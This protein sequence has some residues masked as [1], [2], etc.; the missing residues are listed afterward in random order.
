MNVLVTGS[1]GF[2]GKNLI[3]RLKEEKD[4]GIY[5]YDT[6][7]DKQTLEKYCKA[8]DFV[9]HLAGINRPEDEREFMTGNYG[10][11]L[12]LLDILSKY[13]NQCPVMLSS[14]IQAVYDNNYGRSKKAAEDLLLDYCAKNGAD[15]F[16]CR[17]PNVFGKWCKPNYNSAVAT[18]CHNIARNILITIDEPGKEIKLVYID[19]VAEGLIRLLHSGTSGTSGAS[20]AGKGGTGTRG[21]SGASNAGESGTAKSG[22][23]ENAYYEIHPVYSV[24]LESLTGLLYSF[25]EYR[26]KGYI[27]DLADDFTRKLYGTYL[28]Y[29]P[30]D[31]LSHKLNMHCDHRGSFTEFLKSGSSGQISV[32][33]IKPGITKGNHYH[34]TKTEKFLVVSGRGA[35]RLKHVISG[36]DRE[37]HVSSGDLEVIDIPVGYCHSIENTGSSDMVVIIWCSEIFDKDNPDTYVS[38]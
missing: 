18:F 22:T 3:M 10:F 5:E 14:S 19:D 34:N 12:E 33:V 32:N 20:D 38:V 21:A 27:P 2:I 7:M 1:K 25:Q 6:G 11:T 16:I 15:V 31:D 28:S 30:E 4:I 17:L 13:N 26:S 24:S 36:H 9:Y 8:A 37:F 29:L 23:G 35:I